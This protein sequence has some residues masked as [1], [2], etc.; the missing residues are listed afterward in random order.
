M[1]RILVLDDDALVRR[2]VR[3]VLTVAGHD[4]DEATDGPEALRMAASARYDAALI[5][6]EMPGGMDGLE[7]IGRLRALQPSCMRLLM[8]GRTE[9]DLA[10]TAFNNGEIQR[11][12]PKPFQAEALEQAVSAVLETAKQ[13]ADFVESQRDVAGAERMFQEC[14]DQDLLHLAVQPIVRAGD[15]TPM[16]VECLLRSKHPVL[17]GPLS[18]L[19]AVERSGRVVALGAVVNRLAA[20]WAAKLPTDM[21]VFVNTHCSQFK[22]P[23]FMDHFAPLI[24]HADRVVLEIT[25]RASL[26]TVPQ[27]E[28]AVKDLLSVGFK[29][30]IDDL[31]SGYNGLVMLAD[32]Q[33]SFI[34]VDMSIVRNI[35]RDAR[36]QRLVHLLGSFATATN[37]E[38]VAEGVETASEGETLC[39]IGAHLLQGYHYARPSLEW[40]ARA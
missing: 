9:F 28:A 10:V 21:L 30:A 15:A 7:V 11:F 6:F 40:P 35:D 14:I 12:L 22:S 16:A 27:W 26:A 17:H 5:D 1:A 4:V 3:R 36:K 20:A 38:L 18:V 29:L 32:L 34:K 13:F 2:A 8:T 25:E 37:A 19:D 24:P 33:P 39:R 31:G 23:D